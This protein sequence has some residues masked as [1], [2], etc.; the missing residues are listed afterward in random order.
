DVDRRAGR[1]DLGRRGDDRMRA[2]EQVAHAVA[3]GHMPERAVLELAG[4][5]DQRALAVTL[6]PRRA[7]ERFDQARRHLA[8]ERLQRFHHRLDVFDVAAG[9]GIPDN[10]G[11]A[12]AAQRLRQAR[13]VVVPD[14]FDRDDELAHVDLGQRGRSGDQHGAKLRGRDSG[15]RRGATAGAPVPPSTTA[16]RPC[17][18]STAAMMRPRAISP[19][20]ASAPGAV[21]IAAA[22]SSGTAQVTRRSPRSLSSRILLAG[23][24]TM[25][26]SSRSTALAITVA[27]ASAAEALAASTVTESAM[28]SEKLR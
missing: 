28:P 19:R 2:F 25:R 10:G 26:P 6:D 9:I 3:A 23:R 14:V 5:A 15:C 11:G 20:A 16:K 17:S 12:A 7:A 21:S 8:T 27:A 4:K 22:E 1:A 18:A 24:R 13:P